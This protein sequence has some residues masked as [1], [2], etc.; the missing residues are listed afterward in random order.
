MFINEMFGIYMQSSF[1]FSSTQGRQSQ[2]NPS[3]D[4]FNPSEEIKINIYY[5]VRALAELY[6]FI[7]L[8]F[9]C[10]CTLFILFFF[11]IVAH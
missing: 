1:L 11:F 5:K 4:Y 6:Y 2:Q 9:Y 10:F 8:K 3:I 7:Y